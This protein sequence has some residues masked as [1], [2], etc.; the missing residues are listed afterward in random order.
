VIYKKMSTLAAVLESNKYEYDGK[1]KTP[2]VTIEGLEENKDYTVSYSNN[3]NAGTATATIKGI[4]PYYEGTIIKTFEIGSKDISNKEIKLSYTECEYNGKERKPDVKI[5]GL[6]KGVDYE[7]SYLNNVNVGEAKVIVKGIGN[8]K[9]TIETTFKI[10]EASQEK[11]DIS[12]LNIRLEKDSYIYDG[13]VK[14]PKV[15]IEGLEENKDYV[16]SYENNINIGTAKVIVEGIGNYK[17]AVEKTF[18]IKDSRIDIS[19]LNIML[20]AT[21][22]DYTGKQR[23]ARVIIPGLVQGIDYNVRYE[24]NVNVGDARV[25]I[26]GKGN[27]TGIV[28]KTYV[29]YK[30]MS[31]LAAVLESNKY[32]YDGKEKTPKVTIE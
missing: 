27:Y 4:A 23:P 19:E 31:T 1:E 21:K 13:K 11:I 14:T 10:K 7:V 29:I 12:T 25:I 5:D 8:Y 16:V 6:E 28:T 17:G 3:V 9:G 20:N 26:T 24:N 2:K 32:E 18:K 15:T 22:M 30:K